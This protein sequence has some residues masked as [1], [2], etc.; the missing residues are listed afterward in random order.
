MSLGCA[1]IIASISV[2]L[3][4]QDKTLGT[5]LSLMDLMNSFTG[6]NVYA[7]IKFLSQILAARL[8]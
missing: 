8:E 2:A 3:A 4:E 6:I 1:Q 7:I 5:Y